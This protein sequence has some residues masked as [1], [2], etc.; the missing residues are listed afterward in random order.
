MKL[1]VLLIMFSM[2]LSQDDRGFIYGKIYLKNGK[3]YQG[4][5]RWGNGYG[6]EL[7][8]Q[9]SFDATKVDNPNLKY[10]DEDD[11]SRSGR[12][13]SY[14][15]FGIKIFKNRNFTSNR[16]FNCR[17]GDLRRIEPLSSNRAIVTFKNNDELEVKGS[18]DVGATIYILDKR[19][20]EVKVRWKQIETIEF[21]DTPKKL[22]RKFG[23]LLSGTVSTESGTFEGLIQWDSD[24][25]LDDD[26]LNGVNEKGRDV[27]I[28]FERIES[29]EK[30]SRRSAIVKL[31]S[32]REY[33][34]SGSNDVNSENR[35][36]MI[37]D[38]NFGQVEVQ[39]DEFI[40]VKFNK[41][42]ES[43]GL[44][45]SD[46]GLNEHLKGKLITKE[47]NVSG[48]IVYDL[49]EMFTI[50]ILDGKM[51]DIDYH[52]PFFLIQK[53]EKSGRNG[54]TIYLKSGKTLDLYGTADVDDSNQGIL[55][56]D[57]S[58]NPGYHPWKII[59]SI[60]FN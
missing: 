27:D 5:I 46:F 40:N 41:S 51:D 4:P 42:L 19:R 52:I 57:N 28:R 3:T 30:R 44:A 35:G 12:R 34:L 1:T 6:K 59:R 38:E 50:D 8:W 37:F 9:H 20:G 25:C 7:A 10:I 32:G 17:F 16:Q 29:I 26:E 43:S 18:G 54:S 11:L 58:R 60:E 39:W 13:K 31:F 36:I 21:M 14:S 23:M 22:D 24:E 2:L 33:R 49:D 55:V 45:Y 15:V 47:K 56:F 48:K 53:I